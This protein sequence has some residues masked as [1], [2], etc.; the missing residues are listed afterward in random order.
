[1]SEELY[2]QKIKNYIYTITFVFI[3]ILRWLSAITDSFQF[4]DYY[5]MYIFTLIC[6]L[7]VIIIIYYIIDFYERTIII[8]RYRGK[9]YVNQIMIKKIIKEV[10]IYTI[11]QM[12][13]LEAVSFVTINKDIIFYYFSIMLIA[14]SYN[15]FLTLISLCL[16]KNIKKIYT[17]LGI[18]V[19]L[20]IFI[21]T[22][23]LFSNFGIEYFNFYIEYFTYSHHYLTI[24][25]L[26]L[27]SI[28]MIIYLLD[29][30]SQILS[31]SSKIWSFIILVLTTALCQSVYM[32]YCQNYFSFPQSLGH[33]SDM[34]NIIFWDVPFLVIIQLAFA[35]FTNYYKSHYSLIIIRLRNRTKWLMKI[36]MKQLLIFI[37]CFFIRTIIPIMTYGIMNINLNDWLYS[38]LVIYIFLLLTNIIYLITNQDFAFNISAGLFIIVT[39]MRLYETIFNYSWIMIILIAIIFIGYFLSN[40]I[41]KEKDYI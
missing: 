39:I 40:I 31:F 35:Y 16:Y 22:F 26:A 14:V 37:I 6:P 23:I 19:L 10:T 32:M 15:V 36:Y 7:F 8:L 20:S 11:Y 25:I 30:F 12:F 17:S 2:F 13:I 41:L 1:M 5:I 18:F 38:F 21:R 28:F 3:L 34:M 4:I 9:G 33:G 29:Y 24:G 27:L